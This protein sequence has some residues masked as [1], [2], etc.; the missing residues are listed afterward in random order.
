MHSF[1]LFTVAFISGAISNAE[2]PE[3]GKCLSNLNALSFLKAPMPNAKV[4]IVIQ[5]RIFAVFT[6][7]YFHLHSHNGCQ[8]SFENDTYVRNYPYLSIFDFLPVSKM[9]E[10]VREV[11]QNQNINN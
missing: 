4:I 2:K 1:A 9:Y 11:F 7:F 3:A 8:V 6:P 5:I 10:V